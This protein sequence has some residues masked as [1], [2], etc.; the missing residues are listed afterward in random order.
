MLSS[1]SSSQQSRVTMT[2]T[3]PGTDVRCGPRLTDRGAAISIVVVGVGEGGD[4]PPPFPSNGRRVRLDPPGAVVVGVGVGVA[5]GAPE[6]AQAADER[7]AR[8]RTTLLP[9]RTDG[10]APDDE[11]VVQVLADT[12]HLWKGRPVRAL[13]VGLR[14]TGGRNNHGRITVRHRGGGHKRRYRI[15]DFKRRI[16]D[17]RVG[18]ARAP[19]CVC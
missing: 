5:V 12:S 1:S 14:S 4:A 7:H 9:A 15:I 11:F 10:R 8:H 17:V 19:V 16:V 13:S 6:G 3:S 2:T 18:V